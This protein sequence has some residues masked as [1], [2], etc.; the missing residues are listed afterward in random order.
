MIVC[1]ADVLYASTS[2]DTT[3]LVQFLE[4]I[5][6]QEA[7]VGG[8]VRNYVVH[9]GSVVT[10]PLTALLSVTMMWS[11][12]VDDDD[13]TEEDAFQHYLPEHLRC[14]LLLMKWLAMDEWTMCMDEKQIIQPASTTCVTITHLCTMISCQTYCLTHMT[15]ARAD[16]RAHIYATVILLEMS[17]RRGVAGVVP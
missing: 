9:D 7:F 1:H 11:A 5:G 14:E 10:V 13:G 17:H 3:V 2:E 16:A 4:Y 12:V 8:A 15:H 6:D